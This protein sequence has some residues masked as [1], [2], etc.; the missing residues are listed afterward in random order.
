MVIV[1]SKEKI[2]HRCLKISCIV[3]FTAAF[4]SPFLLIRLLRAKPAVKV[5]EDDRAKNMRQCKPKVNHALIYSS[6]RV[7]AVSRS[8]AWKPDIYTAVLV[9]DINEN[10]SYDVACNIHISADKFHTVELGKEISLARA[11]GH[12][13]RITWSSSN[14]VV[15][16]DRK[17]RQKISR[18]DIDKLKFN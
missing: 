16:K 17:T 14:L 13:G 10:G 15:G 11:M 6:D 1:N 3:F 5:G 2:I 8:F 4:L 18:S 12:W 9:A 7:L